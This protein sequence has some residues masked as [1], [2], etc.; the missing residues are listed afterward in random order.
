MWTTI[1]KVVPWEFVFGILVK[2]ILH[3]VDKNEKN[4][5]AK[6]AFLRFLDEIKHDA[7]VKLNRNYRDQIKA[8]KEEIKQEQNGPQ[9]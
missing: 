7:P 3:F 6:K 4:E 1:L 5:E 8:L 9:H 2:I